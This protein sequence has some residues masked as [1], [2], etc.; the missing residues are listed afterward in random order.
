MDSFKDSGIPR[1]KEIAEEAGRAM[2]AL[3][4]RIKLRLTESPFPDEERIVGE[5]SLDQVRRDM[6]Q[7]ETLG[8]SYV[9]LDTYA[10]DIEEIRHSE[11]SWRMLVTMAEQV[12]DLDNQSLR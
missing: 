9:V 1:L 4:P 10:D 12:L 5:G 8:C 2:P 7:L 6:A 11:T 3:C